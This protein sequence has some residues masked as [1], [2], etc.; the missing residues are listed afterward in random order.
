MKL[1]PY[2]QF[3]VDSAQSVTD[4]MYRIQSVTG[5]STF[6]RNHSACEF[7][8]YINGNEFQ[9]TKSIDYQNAFLPVIEGQVQQHNDGVR[10]A[11]TMRLRMFAIG[12][13]SV[14][15]LGLGIGCIAMLF[16][17]DNFSWP[18]IMPFIMLV[19]GVAMMSGGFWFEASKQKARLV[20]L[21]NQDTQT[22]PAKLGL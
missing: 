1:I 14:W 19:F 8:G 18:M 2:D 17:L 13:M 10:V 9:I 22:A 5:E 20:E 21:L 6:F 15:I 12:F 16:N 11:I 4:V 7:T 3:Y